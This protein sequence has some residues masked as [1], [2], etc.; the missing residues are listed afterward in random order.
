MADASS[1]S[2]WLVQAVAQPNSP[3]RWFAALLVLG[4]ASAIG[5]VLGWRA[6]RAGC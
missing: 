2:A 1:V 4:A 3:W 6:S 5:F